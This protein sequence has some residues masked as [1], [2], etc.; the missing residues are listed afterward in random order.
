[1]SNNKSGNDTSKGQ[2]QEA[3]P[4]VTTPSM[5]V[6]VRNGA[7]KTEVRANNLKGGKTEL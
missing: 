1:M 4:R 5:I 6:K 7:Q 2:N 3:K